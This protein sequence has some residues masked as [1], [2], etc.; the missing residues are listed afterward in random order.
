[1]K[2]N[3][4]E[5]TPVVLLPVNV[6]KVRETA[7]ATPTAWENSDVGETTATKMLTV[8]LTR[9]TTAALIQQMQLGKVA[10]GET[11][12]ALTSTNAGR[13]KV[14]ATFYFTIILYS[15]CDVHIFLFI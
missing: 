7:T 2:L 6:V 15:R 13:T 4:T 3:V 8:G 10:M 12:A 11:I 5:A 1:M 9:L 14:T